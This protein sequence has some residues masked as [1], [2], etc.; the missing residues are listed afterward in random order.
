MN[1][2]IFGLLPPPQTLRKLPPSTSPRRH[3]SSAS[4]SRAPL[5]R[6]GAQHQAFTLRHKQFG[7][8]L[9][10]LQHSKLGV[11]Q[12]RLGRLNGIVQQDVRQIP[13]A[14]CLLS[15]APLLALC[16]YLR[17]FHVRADPDIAA[18]EA[19][20]SRTICTTVRSID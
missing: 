4:T 7:F 3:S 14:L 11:A 10:L 20:S 16:V 18:V 19:K 17:C 6:R 8:H 2:R 5:R 15:L 12:S 9:D 13:E 1:S